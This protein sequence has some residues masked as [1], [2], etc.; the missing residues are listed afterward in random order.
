MGSAGE[1]AGVQPKFEGKL[2]ELEHGEQFEEIIETVEAPMSRHVESS[3]DV[4]QV[5]AEGGEALA[6]GLAEG[7]GVEEL[8]KAEPTLDVI[9]EVPL[10]QPGEGSGQTLEAM[11]S[12]GVQDSDPEMDL[13]GPGAAPA[14]R[15]AGSRP[16]IL[17]AP[18][19]PQ[20]GTRRTGAS[21]RVT[22]DTLA[23]SSVAARMPSETTSKVSCRVER[24]QSE[25]AAQL[26]QLDE[27]LANAKCKELEVKPKEMA[28]LEAQ[29]AASRRRRRP[30]Q[31]R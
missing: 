6:E 13:A 2:K 16:G 15:G 25:A 5:G 18:L 1:L 11:E 27:Q 12:L 24:E 31:P 9:A 4:P 10:V 22:D 8:V 21:N 14:P 29:L 19:S 3:V 20:T 30:R 17:R 7:L 23:Q 28:K 26:S